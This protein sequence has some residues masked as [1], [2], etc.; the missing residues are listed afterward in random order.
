MDTVLAR[1]SSS[2]YETTQKDID[3]KNYHRT[4]DRIPPLGFYQVVN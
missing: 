3:N 1:T 2:S 4:C